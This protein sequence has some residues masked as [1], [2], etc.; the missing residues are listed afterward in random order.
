MNGV[1][2][3]ITKGDFPCPFGLSYEAKGAYVQG[4]Y[5]IVVGRLNPENTIR[6]KYPKSN[7]KLEFI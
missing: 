2:V 1:K 5:I 3:N 7:V 4:K 6:I